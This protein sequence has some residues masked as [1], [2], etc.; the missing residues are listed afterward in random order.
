MKN[1]QLI[2]FFLLFSISFICFSQEDKRNTKHTFKFDITLN[3]CDFEGNKILPIN[4]Q[5]MEKG[6]KFSVRNIVNDQKDY[7]IL[8]SKF[9]GK[10]NKVEALNAQKH[11]KNN[12]QNIYFKISADQYLA[13]AKELKRRGSFVA[14]ASTTLIKI[15]PGNGKE[16]KEE[17]IYS[18]F[19]ND[20]NVGLTAGWRINNYTNNI[21]ISIV[22][23]L[24]F[25]SIKV[26]PQT[27]RN[28][29]DSEATQSSITFRA[30]LILVLGSFLKLINSK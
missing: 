28:F 27:T 5:I 26:T 2:C 11:V 8:I 15:R 6:W 25:S 14:G 10:G 1:L 22:G 30:G 17:A 7:V 29:I 21:S 12:T 20:F 23:G 4:S 13:F 24:S 9:T 16:K 19:G 18:E 3:E